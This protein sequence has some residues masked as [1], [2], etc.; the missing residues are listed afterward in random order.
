MSQHFGRRFARYGGRSV[1]RVHSGL[2]GTPR[3]PL[4]H[5]LGP[6]PTH[7]GFAARAG[8]RMGMALDPKDVARPTLDA[9]VRRSTTVLPGTLT[10][11]LTYS[12]APLPRR[13]RVRIMG[14]VMGGMTKNMDKDPTPTIAQGS[15]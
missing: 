7:S 3:C 4:R 14:R 13:A 10:K 2:Q 15:Q 5:R 8:M 1:L 12:L 11:L 9:L 6:G